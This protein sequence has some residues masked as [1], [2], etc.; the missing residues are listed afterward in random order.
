[1]SPEASQET[2][3]VIDDQGNVTG[4]SSPAQKKR[5]SMSMED[6]NWDEAHKRAK[7]EEFDD[8][9]MPVH[10]PSSDG[11]CIEVGSDGRRPIYNCILE[12]VEEV[13][14]GESDVQKLICLLCR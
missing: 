13:E 6:V 3:P 8:V 11:E 2:K 7:V 14:D 10:S 9:P 4:E 1:M 12:L 5:P